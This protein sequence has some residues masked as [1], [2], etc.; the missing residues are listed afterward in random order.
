MPICC[1]R[2]NAE[3]VGN[4]FGGKSFVTKFD[5]TFFLFRKLGSYLRCLLFCDIDTAD[6]RGNVGSKIVEPLHKGAYRFGND[7]GVTLQFADKT[8]NTDIQQ[9]LYYLRTCFAG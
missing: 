7:I 9:F 1:P 6:N 5:D 3:T 2:R 8:L 4:Q